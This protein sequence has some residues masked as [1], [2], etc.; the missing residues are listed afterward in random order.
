MLD[1]SIGARKPVFF[2]Q[3]GA[4]DDIVS[5]IL[6][7]TFKQYRLT[8]ISITDGAGSLETTLQSTLG[9]LSYFGETDIPIAVSSAKP[10]HQ[11][12][13]KWRVRTQYIPELR[14]LKFVPAGSNFLSGVDGA[15][16]LAKKLLAEEE[17]TTILLTGPATNLVTAITNHPEIA[18]KIEKV[19]WMAGAFLSNGNVVAEDHDGS[20]EWNIFWD[21]FSAQKLIKMNLKVYMFP[22][23]VCK[24]TPVD[25]FLMHSLQCKK[26]SKLC[27]LVHQLLLPPFGLHNKF[28]LWDVVATAWLGN[29]DLAKFLSISADIEIRGTSM[30]NIYR[31]SKGGAI[32]Y[33]N[34]VDDELFYDFLIQQFKSF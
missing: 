6:L 8:G 10:V 28:H 29:Q 13:E 1:E 21:P 9:V 3:D 4:I 5:L 11:F 33:A 12:P 31:T 27:Q 30:G 23:D 17:K 14:R 32:K 15:E 26:R 2:D 16:L 22:I 20:A 19:V 25:S 18:E 34:W 24:L 7:L